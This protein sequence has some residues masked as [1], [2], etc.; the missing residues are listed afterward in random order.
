[1]DVIYSFHPCPTAQSNLMS[2]IHRPPSS[3]GA[4]IRRTTPKE[5]SKIDRPCQLSAMLIYPSVQRFCLLYQQHI[6]TESLPVSEP[7]SRDQAEH[8]HLQTSSTPNRP[9]T[10]KKTLNFFIRSES[11]CWLKYATLN[12]CQFYIIDR[13]L[14]GLLRLKTSTVSW[15]V[16]FCSQ[17]RGLPLL[18]RYLVSC[19]TSV[20]INCPVVSLYSN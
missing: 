10:N 15:C 7:T 13:P 16:F 12:N 5:V 19:I 11:T 8:V 1:M 2:K 20:V 9:T 17:S 14:N 6:T 18:Q 3:I 4:K